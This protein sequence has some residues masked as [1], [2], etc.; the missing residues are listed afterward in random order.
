MAE[1]DQDTPSKGVTQSTEQGPR[2]ETSSGKLGR[3]AEDSPARPENQAKPGIAV[4]IAKLQA[5][6]EGLLREKEHLMLGFVFIKVPRPYYVRWKGECNA[7]FAQ[8]VAINRRR[9]RA[10]KDAKKGA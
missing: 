3:T 7:V 4:A 8:A 5:D 2:D 9:L 10:L 6:V 1:R